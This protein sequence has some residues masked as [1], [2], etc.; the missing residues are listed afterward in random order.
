MKHLD[1]SKICSN[2]F[3][4]MG[5]EGR[6]ATHNYEFSQ[7]PCSGK[8]DFST[9][10]LTIPI[11]I[12]EPIHQRYKELLAKR[13]ELQKKVEELQREFS[14]RSA[15]SSEK[16]G[17]PPRSITPEQTVVWKLTA[18]KDILVAEGNIY[19]SFLVLGKN[20]HVHP[21][22]NKQVYCKL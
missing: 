10:L 14:N 15:S 20:T 2:A 6:G 8:I 13:T 4:L 5:V 12:Q 18:L 1:Y 16:A 9:L 11:W 17:S 19:K 7:I 21:S 3:N 22:I